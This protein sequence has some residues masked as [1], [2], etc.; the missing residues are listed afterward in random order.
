MTQ[1]NTALETAPP[2]AADV[3]PASQ[4][5]A[6]LALLAALKAQDYRFVS[7]TP[8]T[9]ARVVARAG[10]QEARSLTD[11]LGWSLP[12]A[13]GVLDPAIGSLLDRAGMIAAAGDRRRSL[14]R[15]SGLHEHLFLH[16]AFPTDD[17]KAVFFGPDS[18]RF[19]DL[20]RAELAACPG[21]TDARMVDL[22]TGSGV[23]GIVAATA[24]P[25]LAVHMTDV[26]PDALRF[27]RINARAADVAVAT[28]H[29]D[30]LEGI[31]G[32]LDIVTANPPFIIDAGERLYR[33]G[34]ALHGGQTSLDMVRLA[35]PR[36][37]PE[38][39]MI[40]YTGSAIVDGADPLRAA[41]EQVA[42]E[43]GYATRYRELDP[44]IFGEELDRPDYRAVDRIALVAAVITRP[45]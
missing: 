33:H 38:G 17:P 3:D 4:D 44:D 11:I 13:P 12:F 21:R 45:G 14:V 22:G 20:I 15:V 24:C 8:A 40:L 9:H 16:S 2:L 18:Y 1:P 32:A 6:L 35:V 27:A 5:E 34:G 43:A 10:R 29:T 42:A 41:I 39:R 19:A 28:F 37:A 7:P 26:N 30:G 23:G 31:E 25:G 36:L